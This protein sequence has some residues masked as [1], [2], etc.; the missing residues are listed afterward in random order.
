M[1]G[2]DAVVVAAAYTCNLRVD[3]R[4]IWQ[5]HDWDIEYSA[6]SESGDGGGLIGTRFDIHLTD[7]DMEDEFDVR[8]HGQV[9]RAYRQENITWCTCDRRAWAEDHV[10]ASYGNEPSTTTVYSAAAIFIHVPAWPD[11]HHVPK[12]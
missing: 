5:E 9:T 1:K 11:R 7:F 6:T 12:P 8:L 3:L 4:P 10:V 2:A